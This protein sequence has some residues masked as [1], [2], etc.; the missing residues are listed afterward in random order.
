MIARLARTWL[1]AAV[2]AL[3]LL[4]LLLIPQLMR[5]RAGSE[6]LLAVGT[7]LLLTLVVAAVVL[8]PFASAFAAPTDSWRLSTAWGSTRRVWRERRGAAVLAVLVFV[9]GYV[10]SQIVGL[11]IAAA[12]P[13]F[14][15]LPEG[16]WQIHYPAYALQAVVIYAIVTLSLAGYADRI[17]ALA[18]TNREAAES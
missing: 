5:S 7:V 6:Q 4:V 15:A 13:Y 18:V 10:L 17:R 12:V 1:A 2:G 9:A 14:S 16:G 3:P 11:L 8:A